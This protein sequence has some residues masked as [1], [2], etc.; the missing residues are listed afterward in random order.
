[1]QRGER[2]VAGHW[3]DEHAYGANEH[4]RPFVELCD[5]LCT[6]GGGYGCY[7]Y[8]SYVFFGLAYG[9]G[10]TYGDHGKFVR[11]LLIGSGHCGFR[12]G[13]GFFGAP[14][15]IGCRGF[16]DDSELSSDVAVPGQQ[17]QDQ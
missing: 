12:G 9:L 15:G 6:Y 16:S 14:F 13:V 8:Y 3:A 5:I 10:H 1:M 11:V 4:A 7:C 17:G 2:P